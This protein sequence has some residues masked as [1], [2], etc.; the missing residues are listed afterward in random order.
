[1]NRPKSSKE[2]VTKKPIT[3]DVIVNNQKREVL[4]QKLL[5]KFTSMFSH[6]SNKRIIETEVT[7][8]L[9]KDK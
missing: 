7:Q 9:K 5:D 2:G 8:F 1:M 4:K 6:I 3:K